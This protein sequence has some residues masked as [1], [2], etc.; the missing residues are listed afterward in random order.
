MSRLRNPFLT[1]REKNCCRGLFAAISEM[2]KD[3]ATVNS[4]NYRKNGFCSQT[5]KTNFAAD[6]KA[7]NNEIYR[8]Q[9]HNS[10]LFS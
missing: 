9:S 8:E 10:I 4:G 6:T 2:L 7:L 1:Y 3:F 5:A